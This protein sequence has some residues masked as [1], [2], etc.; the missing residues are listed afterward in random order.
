M[1][2]RKPDSVAQR[3]GRIQRSA[4]RMALMINDVLDFARGR[5]D[6]GVPIPR[7]APPTCARFCADIVDELGVANP[8]RDQT[9][10][11]GRRVGRLGPR[12]VAAGDLNLVGNALEHSDSIV[13]IR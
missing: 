12:P 6:S 1:L 3:A 4:A 2:E 13:T 11:H 10:G 5:L 9:G 7:R 8:G